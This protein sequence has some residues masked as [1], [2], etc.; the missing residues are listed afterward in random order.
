VRIA[1]WYRTLWLQ[2]DR[3]Q[4]DSKSNAQLATTNLSLV[5]ATASKPSLAISHQFFCFRTMTKYAT[6]M[7]R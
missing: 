7:P 1:Q 4:Q 3:L 6:N 5:L 2:M